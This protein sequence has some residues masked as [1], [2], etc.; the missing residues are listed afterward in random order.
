MLSL[1]GPVNVPL[2]DVIPGVTQYACDIQKN[3]RSYLVLSQNQYKFASQFGYVTGGSYRDLVRTVKS[4]GSWKERFVD[5]SSAIFQ[6]VSAC[7]RSSGLTETEALTEIS[8]QKEIATL[9]GLTPSD[10][11]ALKEIAAER[12]FAALEEL[13]PSEAAALKGLT[14]SQIA[15][16]KE[17]T[18]LREMAAADGEHK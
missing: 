7:G 14:P 1:T 18:A 2:S 5:N 15:V 13:T 8:E 17:I 6:N 10:A 12:E 9:K 16:L 11:A 4:S 3:R